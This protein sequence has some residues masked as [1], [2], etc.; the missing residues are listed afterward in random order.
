MVLTLTRQFNISGFG[1]RSNKSHAAGLA[2]RG[3]PMGMTI[4]QKRL[5]A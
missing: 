3:R 1:R 4:T 5:P 2:S